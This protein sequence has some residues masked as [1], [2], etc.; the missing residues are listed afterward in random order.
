[1]GLS[2]KG[3]FYFLKE[4]KRVTTTSIVRSN[5]VVLTSV[6]LTGEEEIQDL[7]DVGFAL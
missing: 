7:A 4:E 1:M 2:V 5:I 3:L 6:F